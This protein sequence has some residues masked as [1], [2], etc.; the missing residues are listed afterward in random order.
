MS[1]PSSSEMIENLKQRVHACRLLAVVAQPEA[2]TAVPLA[3]ALWQGGIRGME[4]TFRTAEA[5]E[6]IRRIKEA[7]P[8]MLMGAG[9]LLERGQVHAALEAGADFGVAP[10]FRLEV[11]ETSRELG[12]PFAPGIATPTDIEA[13]VAEGCR[14]LKFFPAEPAGGLAYLRAISEPYA[15]LGIE[16]VPLGGINLE[17]ARDYLACDRVAAI[18]GSWLVP[19]EAVTSGDWEQ[20][21]QTARQA[22]ETLFPA[23]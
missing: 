1:C 10:G 13:A 2:A 19:K 20:V 21:R 9:T 3:Q 4:V 16:Y 5:A 23:R 17:R 8:D 7:V 18:G 12:L 11:L 14:L 6:S 22:V 15:H